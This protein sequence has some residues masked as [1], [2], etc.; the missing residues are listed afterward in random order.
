MARWCVRSITRERERER[1]HLMLL[2]LIL[3]KIINLSPPARGFFPLHELCAGLTAMNLAQKDILGENVTWW[4]V[5]HAYY[6]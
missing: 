5:L 6:F 4:Q 3:L 2:Y 1:E